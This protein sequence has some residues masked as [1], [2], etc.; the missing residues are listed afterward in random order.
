MRIFLTGATGFVGSALVPELIAAGHTVL[1]LARNEKAAK[2]LTAAGAE[3]HRGD[4]EDT[5]S[6]RRGAAAADSVIHTGFIHDFTRFAE[7]CEVDRRA[8]EAMGAALKGT[9]KPFLVTS[10]INAVTKDGIITEDD[11]PSP[12]SPN[13]RKSEQAADKLAAEGVRVS[14]IRLAPSV[15]GKGDY[16]FVPMLIGIARQQGTAAYNQDHLNHWCA[17]HRQDAA[18]LYRLAL[19]KK[20]AAP[21]TRY[22]GVGEGSILFKDIAHKI[23]QG[24][25]IPV[26]AKSGEEVAP[27]FGG[28]APFAAMDMK[29]SSAQ[30]QSVLG[31]QPA[32]PGLLEDMDAG[33]YFSA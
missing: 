22:H 20:E 27:Y 8:I 12:A 23:G 14:V 18:K 13:P 9:D 21:G 26:A 3:V 10:G 31:W 17:V 11:R 32:H 16:G 19:E 29:A 2:K 6:L 28:F 7:M 25:N 5:E 30:T 24:L 33:H 1:G 15:H 4:L